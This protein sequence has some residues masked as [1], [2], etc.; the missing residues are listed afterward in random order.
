M[1]AVAGSLARH[2]VT[3]P[4]RGRLLTD[5]L[6]MT[7]RNL[8]HIARTPQ[9]MAFAAIQPVMFVLLFRF[10][11]GGSIHVPGYPSYID[12]LLPGI[13][14]Q[15]SLFGGSSS[16]IGIADDL[17]KGITDRFRSLPTHRGAI[18][19]GRTFADVL[20]NCF[21]VAL[22]IIVGLLVGFHFHA[23]VLACAEAVALALLFG[24]A[25]SWVFVLV[26]MVVKDAESAQLAAMLPLFPLVFAASTFT[27]TAMMPGWLRAFAN[28]QPVT[29]VVNAVRDLTQGTG[30]ATR[31]TLLALAWSIGILTVAVTVAVRRFRTV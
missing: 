8:R 31:P 18:L 21:T 29:Q 9:L 6:A 22:M 2:P 5:T 7:G 15:T 1:S 4:R 23:G 27:S 28:V 30:S 11:F 19:A 3:R 12:Y 25:F 20:R 17:A 10:V 26:G 13:I 24:Y 14:V 16:A